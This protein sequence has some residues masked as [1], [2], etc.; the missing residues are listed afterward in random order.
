MK[1]SIL[2]ILFLCLFVTGVSFG[3]KKLE[4]SYDRFTDV[5]VA[6][7]GWMRVK[8]GAFSKEAWLE[9]MQFQLNF[10]AFFGHPGQTVTENTDID[11]LGV[12]F[13]LDLSAGEKRIET[14]EKLY[15]IVDGKR[16]VLDPILPTENKVNVNEQVGEAF[17]NAIG[18]N[19]TVA[20][21]TVGKIAAEMSVSLSQTAVFGINGEDLAT[22]ANGQQ[23][24]MKIG[25]IEFKIKKDNLQ[26][27][28]QF[29]QYILKSLEPLEAKL[30]LRKAERNSQTIKVS[31]QKQSVSNNTDAAKSYNATALTYFQ[32][33]Q[34]QEAY[35]AFN[36]AVIADPQ[37]GMYH[38][39]L[40]SALT[41][42]RKFN[43]AEKE[44]L[45]AVRIEPENSTYKTGLEAVRQNI[46]NFR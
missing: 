39:N 29:H 24:E 33:G 26:K 6:T 34:Y 36:K 9:D 2:T 41:S 22:I 8:G 5:S 28:K 1:T 12:R 45:E 4:V 46:K 44:M 37:N 42:L 40:A 13:V 17:I 19:T 38:Y 23:I 3:Q 30:Q 11:K 32:K 25:D 27:L 31:E 15:V 35:N 43:E 18:N 7:T 16:I 20:P 14:N 10:A 21:S